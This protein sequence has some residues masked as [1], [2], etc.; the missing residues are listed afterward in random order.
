MPAPESSSPID[1]YSSL[2]ITYHVKFLNYVLV[3]VICHQWHCSFL[4]LVLFIIDS[5]YLYILWYFQGTTF[6]EKA[7]FKRFGVILIATAFL[8][9]WWLT[10]PRRVLASF[11]FRDSSYNTDSSLIIYTTLSDKGL[12]FLECLSTLPIVHPFG[13]QYNEAFLRGS[14]L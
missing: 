4:D 10:S 3:W 8:A 13:H 2:T 12:R 7:L 5:I 11:Q 14:W 1:W 9:S 6:A